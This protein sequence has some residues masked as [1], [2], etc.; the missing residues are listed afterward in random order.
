M[1]YELSVNGLKVEAVSSAQR[2]FDPIQNPSPRWPPVPAFSFL[3]TKYPSAWSQASPVRSQLVAFV[4][5]PYTRNAWGFVPLTS[6]SVFDGFV[7]F[8]S[9][10]KIFVSPSCTACPLFAIT[11]GQWHVE[12]N[13]KSPKF[14]MP[15]GAVVSANWIWSAVLQFALPFAWMPVEKLPVH[16]VGVCASAVAVATLPL[17]SSF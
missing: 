12:S 7:P 2:M 14:G 17:V 9:W 6:S 1:L 3:R 15:V 4:H 5:V 11:L 16:W 8:E 10:L 13:Q